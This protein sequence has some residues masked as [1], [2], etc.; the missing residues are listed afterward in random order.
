MPARR[1]EEKNTDKTASRKPALDP[2][3]TEKPLAVRED[4]LS[5]DTPPLDVGDDVRAERDDWA[6][7]FTDEAEGNVVVQMQRILPDVTIVDPE[8]GVEIRTAGY[9]EDLP[10]GLP[11]Y[12]NYIKRRYGGGTYRVQKRVAGRIAKQRYVHVQGKPILDQPPAEHSTSPDKPLPTEDFDGVNIGGSDGEWMRR[13]ER[14]M[15]MKKF[16]AEPAQPPAI[17]QGLLQTLLNVLIEQKT[18]DPVAQVQTV[19]TLIGAIKDITPDSN[20]GA[21]MTDILNTAVKTVGQLLVSSPRKALPV[22]SMPAIRRTQI[23]KPVVNNAVSDGQQAT[24]EEIDQ[25]SQTTTIRE[26]AGLAIQTIV[27]NFRLQP[28]KSAD[29]VVAVLDSSLGMDKEQRVELLPFKQV[30][31]DLSEAQLE[32][33][34]SAEPKQR[35]SFQAYF[36]AIFDEF[37]RPDRE[38]VAL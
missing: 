37:V 10:A 30:L 31:F 23:D 33:D 12:Q 8:T 27:T 26:L 1:T 4:A 7:F 22:G 13:M 15:V 25:M 18:P 9:C 6:E 29:R 14:L 35:E 28:P 34:F 11:S 24:P 21:S 3:R 16:L 17:D 20:T 2:K 38:V 19:A 32:E 5:V 36:D